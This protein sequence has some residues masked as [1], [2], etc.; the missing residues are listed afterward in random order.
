VRRQLVTSRADA[1]DLIEAG[2]V[3]VGGAVADKAARLVSPEEHLSVSGPAPRYVSRGGEK[4]EGALRQFRIDPGGKRALD[5]GASTGGFT[6][7][8][9][10]HGAAL[11]TAVDVGRGQIHERIGNDARV[12]SHE[13]TDI[14]SVSLD[15]VGGIPF[16][17]VV[18]DLSFISLRTVAPALVRLAGP[19]AD[20]VVLI[21][22]QFEAGRREAS[23][24]KGV[25]RDPEVWRRA[26]EGAIDA[27]EA[28]GATMMGIMVS[29]RRGADG[30]VEFLAHF[31]VGTDR[32]GSGAGPGWDLDTVLAQ[33]AGGDS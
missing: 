18:A 22:P 3:L 11:V 5:A 12:R 8:L 7:C 10:Q 21:K 29:P 25:I 17:L 6:D 33:A 31:K 14:R 9:L 15:D 19:G 13:R 20:M 1:A 32:P 28:A 23:R 24:G 30:N 16:E 27:L 2:R 26:V 4:L